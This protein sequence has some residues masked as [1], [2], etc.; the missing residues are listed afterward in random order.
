MVQISKIQSKKVKKENFLFFIT[1][2]ILLLT[3]FSFFSE[4]VPKAIKFPENTKGNYFVK[5]FY[6]KDGE[7]FNFYSVNLFEVPFQFK[8]YID[9]LSS[10]NYSETFPFYFISKA[11]EGK[12]FL[13]SLKT[14]EKVE[15]KFWLETCIGDPLSSSMDNYIY[16]LPYEN[17]K[18][19]FVYQ[20]YN[21][22][23]THKGSASYSVD[24]S[25]PIG[26]PICAVRDGI[27][28]NVV[29]N[30]NKSGLSSYY[31]KYANFISIY[32]PDGT[33]SIYAHIKYKGSLVK[34]GQKVKAGQ[35]IG[36]SGNTGRT[37]GPHLHLQ[38]NL[39]IYMSH[40]SIPVPFLNIDGNGYYI[41]EGETYRSVHIEYLSEQ[42]YQ[43]FL[44]NI[45]SQFTIF[46]F[47][48]Y[49]KPRHQPLLDDDTI[50]NYPEEE[51]ED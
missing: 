47:V 17:S 23:F 35:I 51:F 16:T 26:T 48:Y 8:I 14:S 20:G 38:V 11:K 10:F 19:F 36:Y 24:F 42:A 32:H 30:N 12:K 25:M 7:L 1:L 49:V 45:N 34:I 43:T 28:Y 27:V 4:A 15:P 39:P 33:Y 41:K 50:I 5:I 37:S 44:N 3:S 13:F 9:N 29:D 18:E 46:P 40:K 31:T 21:S 6:E 22:N 2:L